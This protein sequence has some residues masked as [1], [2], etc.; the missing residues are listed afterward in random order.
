MAGRVQP[1][2]LLDRP[3]ALPPYLKS[4]PPAPY[5]SNADPSQRDSTRAVTIAAGRG[6]LPGPE[7]R[8]GTAT[9][10]RDKADRQLRH[11]NEHADY[12]TLTTT[13]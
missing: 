5:L 9:S 8:L 2:G 11:P 10:I 12:T 13:A 3:A 1:L 6:P 7:T 4:V